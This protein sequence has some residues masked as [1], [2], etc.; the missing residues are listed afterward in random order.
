MLCG[1][2]RQRTRLYLGR[3]LADAFL[4]GEWDEAGLLARGVASLDRRPGWLRGVV[5]AVLAGYHRPPAD[6]PRELAAFIAVTL[7]ARTAAQRD[8]PPP[9]VVR[10]FVAES[11]M[12]RRPW[13]VPEL[14]T[15]GELAAFLGLGDGELA[16]LAAP[17]GLERTVS[18]EQLRN[19]HY[20]R[21][22]RPGG[23]PRLIER[24]KSRLKAAQRTVLHEILDWIP[25]HP[26]AHGFTRGRPPAHARR[27]AHGSARRGAPRPRGL[28]R[29][30]RGA[31][32]LRDLPHGGLSRV[33][34]ARAD[35]PEH[36]RD[37][38]R[39][40]GRRAAPAGP[41]ARRRPP[42]P[43]SPPGH[44]APPAGRPDLPRAR[45][46]RGLPARPP[47]RRARPRVRAD[48]HPLRR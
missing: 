12:G 35:G 5:R 6:R 24:P 7:E 40:M 1:V 45:Q 11:R 20:A 26:A 38:G 4:A 19:Y 39:R 17:R 15:T 8:V 18:D 10:R 31:S 46:P 28:L 48:V 13:P 47:P 30:R 43:R 3:S 41:R 29:L 37:P 23:P 9:R 33:G 32:H 21:L 44:A 34:G 27:P 22:P 36:E 25:A 42:P 14:A 16:W 2:Y